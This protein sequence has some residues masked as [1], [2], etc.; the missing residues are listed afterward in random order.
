MRFVEIFYSVP[1]FSRVQQIN[2]QQR[3]KDKRNTV[4]KYQP[5]FVVL[6]EGVGGERMEN[7][8]ICHCDVSRKQAVQI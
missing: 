5:D 4:D 2:Y 7:L 3:C 1:T 6:C 8:R